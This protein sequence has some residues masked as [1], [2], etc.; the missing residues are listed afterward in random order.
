V[1]GAYRY[2]VV[3]PEATADRPA[4]AAFRAWLLEEARAQAAAEGAQ[5]MIVKD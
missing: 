3:C 1:K 2:Y 5:T 4:L